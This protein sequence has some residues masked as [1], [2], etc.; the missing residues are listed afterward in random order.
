ML[1]AKCS[2]CKNKTQLQAC[3][4]CEEAKCGT[5]AQQ[6]LTE[7]QKELKDKWSALDAKIQSI[8]DP[9]GKTVVKTEIDSYV[10][11]L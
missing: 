7:Y 4:I 8:K 1:V 11:L 3:Q 5:C 6:H 9:T 2:S 10:Y